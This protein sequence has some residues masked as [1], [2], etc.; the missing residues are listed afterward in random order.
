MYKKK[1]RKKMDFKGIV[2]AF[3]QNYAGINVSKCGWEKYLRVDG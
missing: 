2:R 3:C 1:C